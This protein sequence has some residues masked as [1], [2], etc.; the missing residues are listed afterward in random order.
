M[1]E[2][3]ENDIL[4]TDI[5]LQI[6]SAYLNGNDDLS[7]EDLTNAISGALTDPN[8][9][10]PGIMSGLLYASIVHMALLLATLTEALGDDRKKVLQRYAVAYSSFRNQLS[11]MPQLRPEFVNQIMFNFLEQIN[12]NE[13]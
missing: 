7:S 10:G 8:I 13:R 5:V 6:L 3:N 11:V 12:K 9:A 1:K 4:Y 2:F